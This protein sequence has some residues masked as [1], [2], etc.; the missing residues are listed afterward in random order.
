MARFS[1]TKLDFVITYALK[2]N[3]ETGLKHISPNS[4]AI[5]VFELCFLETD[6]SSEKDHRSGAFVGYLA[7][8]LEILCIVF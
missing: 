6:Y 2:N 8:K 3:K 5:V 7:V 4:C 1:I